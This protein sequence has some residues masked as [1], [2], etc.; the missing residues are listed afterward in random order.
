[1][2]FL[3]LLQVEHT[4]LGIP[5]SVPLAVQ[6]WEGL[7][8]VNYAARAKGVKRFDPISTAKEKVVYSLLSPVLGPCSTSLSLFSVQSLVLA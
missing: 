4:R 5:L 6:Q 1:M 7:V 8:A 3:W 2:S